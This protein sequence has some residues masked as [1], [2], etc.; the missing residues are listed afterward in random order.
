MNYGKS[1]YLGKKPAA[2]RWEDG[3]RR[4]TFVDRPGEKLT[5]EAIEVSKGRKQK[6]D[7]VS[8]KVNSCR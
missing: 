6:R 1:T 8:T 4:K 5:S 2:G 3:R 7:T